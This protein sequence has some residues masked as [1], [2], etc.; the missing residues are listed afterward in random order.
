[1]IEIRYYPKEVSELVPETHIK[2]MVELISKGLNIETLR[3]IDIKNQSGQNE[4]LNID[5]LGE[6]TSFCEGNKLYHII[7]LYQDVI[8][9]FVNIT[10]DDNA[11][12]FSNILRHEMGHIHDEHNLKK[13][14]EKLE[15]LC[16]K[17]PI[18]KDVA[19]LCMAKKIWSE[20]Y[21][22]YV[23]SCF[24]DIG[25][26]NEMI[27]KINI[28]NKDIERSYA[29]SSYKNNTKLFR[30]NTNIACTFSYF[31]GSVLKQEEKFANSDKIELNSGL[32]NIFMEYVD[33]L[34]RLLQT[35]PNWEDETA[36]YPLKD[37]FIK[38]LLLFQ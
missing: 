15:L 16:Q 25:T 36:F 33:E 32:E 24:M 20:F 7:T 6:S 26:V 3:Y 27:Q 10:K 5:P 31:I 22:S 34:E 35:Y 2:K 1:M 29:E 21:A 9:Y 4:R 38:Q 8:Y 14:Y 19:C 30:A 23:S 11:D 12:R 37:I 18:S 17:E 13:V 28:Q